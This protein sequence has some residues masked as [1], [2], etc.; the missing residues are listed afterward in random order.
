[1]EY[2]AGWMFLA[3]TIILMAGFPVAMTLLGTALIFGFFVKLFAEIHNV[4]AVLTQRR[5][6]GRGRICLPSGTLKL[7][8]CRYVLLFTLSHGTLLSVLSKV[9]QLAKTQLQR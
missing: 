2:L 3:L 4:Y 6:N 5:T 9:F 1:M 8:Q 7:N